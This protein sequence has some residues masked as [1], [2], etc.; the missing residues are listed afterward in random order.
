M[1]LEL[2][3]LA[4]GVA[5]FGLAGYWD[6]KTTEFPDWLPYSLIIASLAVKGGWGFFVSDLILIIPITDF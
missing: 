6:L 5:G 1:I 3:L 4:I 2:I